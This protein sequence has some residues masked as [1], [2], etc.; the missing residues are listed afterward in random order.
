MTERAGTEPAAERPRILFDT[1]V[2]LDVLLDREPWVREAAALFEAVAD[3]RLV[4]LLAGHAVT[5]VYYVFR[6]GRD[7]A[8]AQAGVG[9]LLD[10]FEVAPVGRSLP[11]HSPP[12]S[13]TTRTA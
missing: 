5:T 8:E 6:A 7:T 12:A 4:G 1:N 10:L 11:A 3:R 2:V 13:P 9:R